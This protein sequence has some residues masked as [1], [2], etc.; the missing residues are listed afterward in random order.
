MECRVTREQDMHSCKGRATKVNDFWRSLRK[1]N[2]KRI[3][4]LTA[5]QIKKYLEDLKRKEIY[6]NRV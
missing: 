4:G 3:N 6:E 2:E 5:Q 1:K